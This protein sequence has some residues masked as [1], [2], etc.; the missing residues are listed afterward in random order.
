VVNNLAGMMERL[1]SDFTKPMISLLNIMEYNAD[2]L[3]ETFKDMIGK[4]SLAKVVQSWINREV[5]RQAVTGNS[6]FF[7][8]Y[9]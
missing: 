3:N 5:K 8:Q 2:K 1:P 4:V 6:Y 7:M 9:R